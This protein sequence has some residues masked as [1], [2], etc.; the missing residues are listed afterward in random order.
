[1]TVFRGLQKVGS[2]TFREC[3]WPVNDSFRTAFWKVSLIDQWQFWGV[4]KKLD[5]GPL[6]SVIDQSMT[7]LEQP[8]KSVIDW[9]MTVF[10]GLQKV[11][12]WTFRECHWPVNDSFRTAFWKLSLTGQ[13]QFSGVSKKL[14]PGPLES[15]IDWS[16]TVL[17]QPSEKCH[18][19]V[20][21]NFQGSPKSWILDL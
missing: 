19:P 3:H 12:S 16:M 6:E 8:S 10:G 13:W 1:M 11:G 7:V 20:N 21:D 2:W 15:V 17:E 4:S 5:P 18:W 9:S 14:D